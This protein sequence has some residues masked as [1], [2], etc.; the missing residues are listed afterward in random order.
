[1]FDRQE[2]QLNQNQGVMTRGT[3]VERFTRQE[4][5]RRGLNAMEYY[6]M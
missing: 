6:W 2:L 1:M 5:K 4:M 3:I